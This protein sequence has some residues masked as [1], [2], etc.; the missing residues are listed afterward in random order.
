MKKLVSNYSFNAAAKQITLSDYTSIDLESLLLITN[1][2]N[3]TII[4]NFAGQGKGATISG[5]VLT[6]DYDTTSM[7]NTDD[8]QVFIDDGE[9]PAT[10][11]ALETIDLLL[12][13]LLKRSE[14]LAVVDTAQRQRV[15]VEGSSNLTIPTV[16]VNGN[17]SNF[18]AI[19]VNSNNAFALNNALSYARMFAVPDIWK[20]HEYAR[21]SYEQGIR[22]KL[23]F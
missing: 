18:S 20:M 11:A 16:T 17:G 8:L 3:N 2:S 10:N 7:S 4:Y 21:Q 23:T 12:T 13:Q 5:N 14:S 22:S 1:V 9:S 19:D 15:V 6:L